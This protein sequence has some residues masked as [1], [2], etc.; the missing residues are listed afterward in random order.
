[1]ISFRLDILKE[2]DMFGVKQFAAQYSRTS[3]LVLK[4][5]ICELHTRA[6]QQALKMDELF[7][8]YKK[9]AAGTMS[10][11]KKAREVKLKQNRRS[12]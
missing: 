10:L 3:R 9:I 2:K 8:S 5:N 11:S 7:K 4:H 1:M 12:A 6:P